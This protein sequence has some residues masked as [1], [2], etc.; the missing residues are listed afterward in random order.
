[1]KLEMNQFEKTKLRTYYSPTTEEWAKNTMW[2]GHL[3]QADILFSS[4]ASSRNDSKGLWQEYG[5]DFDEIFVVMMKMET[6]CFVVKYHSSMVTW[7]KKS[8]W[9]NL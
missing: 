9:N 3:T 8:K 5:F 2:M 6:L 4:S 7:T 1:M